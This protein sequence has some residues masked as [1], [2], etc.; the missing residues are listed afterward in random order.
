MDMKTTKQL[1][2]MLFIWLLVF[3]TAFAYWFLIEPSGTGWD[4]G[5]DRIEK[6]IGWQFGATILALVIWWSGRGFDKATSDRRLSRLPIFAFFLLILFIAGTIGYYSLFAD[7]PMDD[8][9]LPPKTT[10]TLPKTN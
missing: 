7:L 8:A 9:I 1:Y 6:F 5:L 2:F 10:T 4:K 3:C